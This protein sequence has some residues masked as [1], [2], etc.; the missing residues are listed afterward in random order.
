M[1]DSCSFEGGSFLS[2]SLDAACGSLGVRESLCPLESRDHQSSP[3][4]APGSTQT[5]LCHLAQLL[6]L[7]H[8]AGFTGLG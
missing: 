6:I 1:I 8:T 7:P 5:P 4:I 2:P 3:V